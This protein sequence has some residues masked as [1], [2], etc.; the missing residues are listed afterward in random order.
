MYTKIVRHAA[1]DGRL[2]PMATHPG[3]VIHHI[4][5]ASEY[6][7]TCQ[8]PYPIPSEDPDPIAN[9]LK[10]RRTPVSRPSTSDTHNLAGIDQ[11]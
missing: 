1:W 3:K 7:Q 5:K 6:I 11:N 10:Y 4:Y 9:V 8:L 2:H